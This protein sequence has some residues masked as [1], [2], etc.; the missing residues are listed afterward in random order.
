MNRSS[1]ASG[2]VNRWL[3]L[4]GLLLCLI[5]PSPA[6]ALDPATVVTVRSAFGF[7]LQPSY[8]TTVVS[9]VG[10]IDVS[11]GPITLGRFNARGAVVDGD[12]VLVAFLHLGSAPVAE[13]ILP[14]VNG[15]TGIAVTN[16]N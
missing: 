12:A 9:G 11:P 3:F 7:Q 10:I 5:W 15:A 14:G 8:A 4:A 2:H 1:S 16:S 6:A 13:V